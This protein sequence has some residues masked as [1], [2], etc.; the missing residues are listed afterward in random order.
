M[1]FEKFTMKAQEALATAQ[2]TAMARSHTVVS[3]LHLLAAILAEDDGVVVMILK[4]IGT[5]VD[6]V[7]EMTESELGRLPEGKSAS[8]VMMPDPAFGQV[9]LDAQNR[10]DKMGDEY[11]SVEH[12]FMSLAEIKSDAKEILSVNSINA[13]A[14]ESALKQI[15]G[16]EKVTDASPESRYKALERFGID[17]LEMAR[18]GKLDPVIGREDEIRRCMQV[19]NRRT[20]NNPVL[21]GEPGVG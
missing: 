5:S 10:A 1:Q 19:L 2:Q 15:R 14:I 20:K 7:K 21:I 16:D 18:K 11:L 8:Q 12:L 3:P 9:V 13:E 6:R 4:K 17:L